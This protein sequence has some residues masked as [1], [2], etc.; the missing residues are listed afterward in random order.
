MKDFTIEPYNLLLKILQ[1]RGYFF[2][3]FSQFLDKPQEKFIILR[4]DID[5]LP[6][7]SLRFAQIEHKLGIKGT[8]YFRIVPQS[9]DPDIIEKIAALGHEIGYHYEDIDLAA[10]IVSSSKYVVS[11]KKDEKECRKEIEKRRKGD[12]ELNR[13]KDKSTKSR[14]KEELAAVAIELFEKHLDQFRKYYPI[15]TICMHGSPLSKWDNKD[16]WKKYNYKD[17]GIIGEPYFDID[18][19]KVLYLTDTGRRWN[20]GSVSVRD[21]AVGGRQQAEGIDLFE[22][23]VVKPKPG[24]LINMTEK[25]VEF[26][27]RYNFRSTNDIIRAAEKGELP[28]KIMITFHSQRWTDKAV[29]WVKELVW[30]N[31]KNVG[32]WVLVKTR[33]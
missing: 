27:S 10:K 20:G 15:Q 28:D 16:L 26:Q 14:P 21:K 32:K 18:F 33:Q 19:S 31:V 23:W 17:F 24:S 6:K 1:I 9:F 12:R 30:Q 3:P 29:P 7:N 5:R 25:G 8:Y 11:S 22:D 4:H 2:Q 13:R